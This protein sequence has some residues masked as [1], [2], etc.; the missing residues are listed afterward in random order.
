[1]AN[2]AGGSNN[3]SVS[4]SSNNGGQGNNNNNNNNNLDNIRRYRTAFT[5]EQIG[6]LEK[7]FV[8]ENYISRWT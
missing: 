1:M 8:K 3:G 2:G 5:R 4:S 6:R 7:E